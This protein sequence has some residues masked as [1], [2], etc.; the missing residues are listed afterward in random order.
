MVRFTNPDRCTPETGVSRHQG[1]V[2]EYYPRRRGRPAAHRAARPPDHLQRFPDGIEGGE[3]CRSGF[4]KHPRLSAHR[5]VTFPSGRTADALSHRPS[6]IAWAAQMGTVTFHPWQVRCPDTDHPDEL[7]VDLDLQPEQ[8]SPRLAPSPSTSSS[9]CWTELGL[10]WLPKTSGGRG[11]HVFLRIRLDWDFVA[12]RR[13][14]SR[15]PVR[16]SG[17]RRN[18]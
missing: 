10:V 6:A 7:R 2:M 9:R 12:V 4:P 8:D 13:A 11:V 15:W 5:R 18:W 16:S 17:A 3:I 1:K 14:E